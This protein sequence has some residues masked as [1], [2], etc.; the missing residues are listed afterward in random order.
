MTTVAGLADGSGAAAAAA[1]AT[2]ST[3][4]ATLY[5][6]PLLT[7]ARVRPHA[8]GYDAVRGRNHHERQKEG[9]QQEGDDV[10]LGCKNEL[11]KK[12]NSAPQVVLCAVTFMHPIRYI[13]VCKLHSGH[14]AQLPRSVNEL[15][16]PTRACTFNTIIVDQGDFAY[17]TFC[18]P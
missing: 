7:R 12:S 9:D 6:S 4:A 3:A 13:D 10:R 17:C 8:V 5:A 14:I 1:A 11:K 15:V 16:R 2:V 18:P